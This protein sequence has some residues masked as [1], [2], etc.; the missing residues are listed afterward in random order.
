MALSQAK[1][2]VKRLNLQYLARLPRAKLHF[3]HRTIRL[4]QVKLEARQC[5]S[6]PLLRRPQQAGVRQHQDWI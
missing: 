6:S 4:L 2:V 3:T 5:R 1:A